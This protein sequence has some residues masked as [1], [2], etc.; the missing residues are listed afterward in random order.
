MK[1]F[2]WSVAVVGC[3]AALLQFAGC[4]DSRSSV[5]VEQIHTSEYLPDRRCPQGHFTVREVSII[6]G[7]PERTAELQA[8]FREGRAVYGGET[9]GIYGNT[10]NVCSTCRYFYYKVTDH[11]HDAKGNVVSN[12]LAR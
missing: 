9:L 8:A 2:W 1:Y 4:G 6:Y 7:Q 12:G 10:A 5:D 3:L 11:W